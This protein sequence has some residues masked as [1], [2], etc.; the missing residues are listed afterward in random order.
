M[1]IAAPRASTVALLDYDPELGRSIAAPRR[2]EA[3]A[4]ALVTMVS[5]A[6]GDGH[7]EA[8]AARCPYGV[9]LLDGLVSREVALAGTVS[10]QLLG[11]GD[12]LRAGERRDDGFVDVDVAWRVLEPTGVALLDDRFLT[13]VRRWPELVAALFERIAAQ[14]ARLGTQRALCQLPR[15]EDR[16]QA[17]LWF[18]AERWGR[19]TAQGV[20][21]PLRL[22]HDAIGRLVGAKRPTVSLAV[23]LLD[24]R[25]AVHR[26]EDGAWL[27]GEP[28][29]SPA[30]RPAPPSKA[31]GFVTPTPGG[32][33][34]VARSAAAGPPRGDPGERAGRGLGLVAHLAQA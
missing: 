17:L 2:A 19:L 27:L 32:G 14:A 5:L 9:L 24:D 20:V 33:R 10:M 23:K 3:R 30:G 6:R 22:T 21:V 11:R 18:L 16:I 12:L 1:T 29:A 13:A 15:V 8:L 28:P 34:G 25:G 4:R 26:R 7:V 31:A